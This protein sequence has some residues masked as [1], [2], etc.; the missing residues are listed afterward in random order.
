MNRHLEEDREENQQIYAL[1]E[2]VSPVG[3]Q[4]RF[5]KKSHTTCSELEG[6]VQPWGKRPQGLDSGV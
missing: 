4:I 6:L 3:P 2:S 1:H 5:F